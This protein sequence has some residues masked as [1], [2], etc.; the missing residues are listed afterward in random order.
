VK[1][2]LR[3]L[4]YERESVREFS[5]QQQ[6]RHLC[7][8]YE[9]VGSDSWRHL[10]ELLL[11]HAEISLPSNGK[12]RFLRARTKRF[13]R[14]VDRTVKNLLC[15]FKISGG[16]V[17]VGKILENPGVLGTDGR[18]SLHIRSGL[19]PFALATLDRA[20]GHINF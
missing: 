19:F 9:T 5:L 17:I 10:R 6:K 16:I 15:S 18:R 8:C 3:R 4:L 1:D 14:S 12:V 11:H 13:R 2:I 7:E 20:N